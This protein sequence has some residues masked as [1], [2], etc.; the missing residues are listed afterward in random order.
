M[1]WLKNALEEKQSLVCESRGRGWWGKTSLRK[2][3]SSEL[4]IGRS[5]LSQEKCI[6]DRRT[7]NGAGPQAGSSSVRQSCHTG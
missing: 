2:K 7:A 5:W 4:R 3:L 6:P 1:I